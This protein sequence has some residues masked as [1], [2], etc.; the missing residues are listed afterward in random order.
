[1]N[2]CPGRAW[3][4]IAITMKLIVSIHVCILNENQFKHYN[5]IITWQLLSHLLMLYVC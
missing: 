5:Y 3:L 4:T 1:M 2:V